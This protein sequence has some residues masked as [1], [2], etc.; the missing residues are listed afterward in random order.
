MELWT[1]D[2]NLE[3]G[4]YR[5]LL[6]RGEF[7]D[8]ARDGREVPFKIYYPTEHHLEKMPVVLWSHG[9]GGSRDGASF[10]SRY[11]AA[12][13]YTVVH[14][15]HKGTDSSLWEG[16]K[17]HPWDVLRKTKVT[18]ETTLNRMYDVP[19]VLDQLEEWASDNPDPGAFMDLSRIGM[20]GH[21]FGAMTTQVMAGM[22]FPDA[23]HQLRSLREERIKAGILYSPTPIMHL[24]DAPHAQVYGGINIPLFH[25]TGT[26]DH[27]P[28]EHHKYEDRL[29]IQEHAQHPEQYLK[30]LEGGDHMVY[31]GSRGKLAHNPKREEYEGIIKAASLAFWDA[32]LKDDE[33][34]KA[35]LKARWSKD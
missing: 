30:I 17:E 18:R 12:H 2:H 29:V 33:A 7:I 22:L 26:E 8:F 31:T 16:K 19:F 21:S 35:W 6:E 24:T 32:H 15:T 20:S 11:I 28:L 10:I 4:P 5:V 1:P 13:G 23:H 3:S 34:A 25:M 14:L 27:S 9:F